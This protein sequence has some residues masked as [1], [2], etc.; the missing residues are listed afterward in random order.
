MGMAA[1]LFNGAE[2]FQ[3]IDNY[4]STDGP[5]WNLEKLLKLFSKK[6]MFKNNM[7]YTCI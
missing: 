6:K 1:I 7:I 2:P 5:K 3:Q 4:P